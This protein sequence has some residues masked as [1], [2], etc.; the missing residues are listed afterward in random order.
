[1]FADEPMSVADACL[2]S[3]MTITLD[4]DFRV[5]RRGWSPLRLAAPFAAL[6]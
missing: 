4:S 6:R 5:Y 2:A 1:M 3:A